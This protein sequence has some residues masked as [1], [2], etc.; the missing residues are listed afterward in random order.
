MGGKLG[1]RGDGTAS[2]ISMSNEP[3]LG[4]NDGG[5]GKGTQ[6]DLFGRRNIT[7][8]EGVVVGKGKN[9]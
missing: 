9:Y 5:R 4:K 7:V 6:K 3:E 8:G 1:G 2:L